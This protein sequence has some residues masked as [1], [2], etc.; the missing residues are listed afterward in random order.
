MQKRAQSDG[1]A[2]QSVE[3]SMID[4]QML[5]FEGKMAE[6]PEMIC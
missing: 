6:Q 1:V 4:L 5:N 2:P 3:I